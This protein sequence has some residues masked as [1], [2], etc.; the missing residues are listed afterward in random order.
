M[1]LT[2]S[3]RREVI[4]DLLDIRIFSAMNGLIKDQIRVR[5]DQV[6]SLELKKD[7]LKDKMKMQ[8]NFIEELENRGNANIDYNN[9]KISKLDEELVVYM[10]QNAF[11]KKIFIVILRSKK[12]LLV[13]AIS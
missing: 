3:N 5:R 8:Q 4:E 10:K 13:L 1:Q 9:E 11:L 12:R 2:T 7:T 6:K